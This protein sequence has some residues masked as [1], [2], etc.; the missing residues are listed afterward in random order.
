MASPGSTRCCPLLLGLVP[1]RL[2]SCNFPIPSELPTSSPAGE[3][4]AHGRISSRSTEFPSWRK[5]DD[6]LVLWP[7]KNP[8]ILFNAESWSLPEMLRCHYAS[9]QR[10]PGLWIFNKPARF[11][12]GQP[13]AWES[14][15]CLPFFINKRAGVSGHDGQIQSAVWAPDEGAGVELSTCCSC[16][17]PR[18]PP[19]AQL[20]GIFSL[21]P[22]PG[23]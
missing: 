6:H 7:L 22:L 11:L 3:T 15:I 12:H 9:L 23:E 17:G 16:Q 8:K 18:L 13:W 19:A 21:A 14:L 1:L 2:W 10:G 20:F 5:F 4:E